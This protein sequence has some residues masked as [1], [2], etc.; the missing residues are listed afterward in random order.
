MTAYGSAPYFEHYADALRPFYEKK[1][2]FLFDFNLELMEWVLIGKMGWKGQF[3]LSETYQLAAPGDMPD[4]KR[5]PQV[6]E[7][8][9]GFLSDLS[10][11]DLLFCVGKHG[12]DYLK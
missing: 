10:V 2:P 6:F 4:L 9:H 12:A 11:L 3:Q 7:A 1:Q 5:Y 8:R